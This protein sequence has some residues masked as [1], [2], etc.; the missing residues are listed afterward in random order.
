M[1][2]CVAVYEIGRLVYK[3]VHS[4]VY[5]FIASCPG[6]CLLSVNTHCVLLP[7][8]VL[9]FFDF[10]Y[11]LTSHTFVC[12]SQNISTRFLFPSVLLWSM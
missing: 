6:Q 4:F 1:S 11:G 8:F 9:F 10:L 3:L 12:Q 7:S 5:S 2:V